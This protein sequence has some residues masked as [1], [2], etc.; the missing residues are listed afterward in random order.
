M[1]KENFEEFAYTAILGLILDNRFKPGDFLFET[2]LAN[3]LGLSRTPVRHALGQLVAEGFLEKKKKKGCYIPAVSARDAQQVF[4]LR[5]NI[6][7]LAAASAARFASDD[8]IVFLQA[9]VEKEANPDSTLSKLDVLEINKAFHLGI[10]RFS[11]NRYLE[12]YCRHIFWRSNVYVFF[13]DNYY[14]ENIDYSKLKTPQQHA[15]VVAALENRNDE[16]AGN[17]MKFH[18][19][20]TYEMLFMKLLHLQ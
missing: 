6:E 14:R 12:H 17:L 5:E 10:A 11:G 8:D 1:A 9:L 2:E 3:S 4:S 18:I 7:G 19:R 16:K 13:Y 15:R 20:S